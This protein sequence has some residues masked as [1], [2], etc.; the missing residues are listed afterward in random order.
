MRWV[1]F[2]AFAASGVACSGGK[3]TDPGTAPSLAGKEYKCAVGGSV[4]V[5]DTA[6]FV[7]SVTV[8]EV[9]VWPEF[10]N[11]SSFGPVL[12]VQVGI[13]SRNPNKVTNLTSQYGKAYVKDDLGNRYETREPDGRVQPDP[14]QDIH[15]AKGVTRELRSDMGTADTILFSR[16][17]PGA[18]K[19]TIY[20]SGPDYGGDGVIA[21]EAPSPKS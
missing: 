1:L 15:I 5:G 3:K 21:I 11:A 16:P 7:S 8:G 4:D 18:S 13:K 17:V 10:G 9:L 19:L 2:F 6:V 12:I 14:H 20:L